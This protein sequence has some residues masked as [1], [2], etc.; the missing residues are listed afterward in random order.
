M[1]LMAA[2]GE[3]RQ[4]RVMALAYNGHRY[5]EEFGDREIDAI[6]GFTR[7][8]KW[9]EPQ[10]DLKGA[11]VHFQVRDPGTDWITLAD[12]EVPYRPFEPMHLTMA[13]LA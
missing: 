8:A 9:V 5:D 1:S 3:D 12:V 10:P 2:W 11:T 7:I 13:D 4:Y 6:M